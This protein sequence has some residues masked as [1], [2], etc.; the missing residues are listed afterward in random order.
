MGIIAFI[1]ALAYITSIIAKIIGIPFVLFIKGLKICY[2]GVRRFIAF[3]ALQ[4]Y[5][6]K[7]FLY[8]RECKPKRPKVRKKRVRAKK[9]RKKKDKKKFRTCLK[10][11]MMPEESDSRIVRFFKRIFWISFTFLNSIYW[12]AHS[13]F[14]KVYWRTRG[15]FQKIYWKLIHPVYQKVYWK[16]RTILQKI[17]WKLLYPMYQKVYWRTRG[18]FQKLYWGVRGLGNRI[19]WKFFSIYQ[20]IYWRIRGIYQKIYWTWYTQSRIFYRYLCRNDYMDLFFI[21]LRGYLN[22]DL[23]KIQCIKISGVK[24][25][26]AKDKGANDYKVIESG[27]L[28]TVCIPEYFEKSKEELHEYMSPDIYIA[29][30][31]DTFLIGGSNVVMTNNLL[32]SDTAYY[33]KE[34]R[35]DIRYGAIK[36]ELGNIAVIEE[37]PLACTFEK[38]INLIGAASFNYYHLV[39]EIL[40]R[41]TF[42]DYCEEYRDYPILVDEI[43]LK[44]PQYHTALNAINKYGH[45]IIKL[46]KGKKYLIE[47]LIQPSSNVW[48]PTNL[49]KR[50]MIRIDD[51]LMADSVLRNIRESVTLYK[52]KA[53]W[54]KI[55]ISRK[56]S[57]AV[58]LK[59][60]EQI[61]ELFKEN[62][63]EI[64]YT[65]EMSFQQQIECFGQSKIIVA[66]S[67][68]ALTN[69]LFCQPGAV[70]GCIIPSYH[71]FYMYSTIAHLLNLHPIFL[72]ANITTLTQYAA[73]DT[74]VLDVEYVE[75]YITEMTNRF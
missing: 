36:K 59:N 12:L 30:I 2:R 42:V 35:I 13:I 29:R 22:K 62:G 7:H 39:I 11:K 17:Y 54:R 53:P 69:I 3:C 1:K 21:F 28:R 50:Q 49:Y 60:E 55:F 44:I 65:E 56:N 5:K 64:I 75:R 33:D 67:G 31:S 71:N 19:Y 41:L 34:K 18:V 72:D 38:G 8:H 74:F 66:S 73:A 25:F 16:T 63:Y 61:R 68:A 27:K 10:T 6:L 37:S 51:F 45:P 4:G 48:M 43:V 32:L 15:I 46:E 24:D 58:R 52:E 20:R 9:I 57:Q 26:I 47:D 70:I 14:R 40:S 23:E